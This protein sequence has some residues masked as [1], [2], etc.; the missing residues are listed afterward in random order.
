MRA[1]ADSARPEGC[2]NA[3]DLHPMPDIRAEAVLGRQGPG[4]PKGVRRPVAARSRSPGTFR[5]ERLHAQGHGHLARPRF[6]AVARGFTRGTALTAVMATRKPDGLRAPGRPMPSH[7]QSAELALRSGSSI[8]GRLP[9][10]RQLPRRSTM[11]I[12]RDQSR[13]VS[14]VSAPTPCARHDGKQKKHFGH[15]SDKQ[16]KRGLTTFQGTERR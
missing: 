11:P 3:P 4:R 2:D 1:V 7:G 10:A 15:V 12:R 6:S 16:P 5:L 8:V 13:F 9:L 14:I